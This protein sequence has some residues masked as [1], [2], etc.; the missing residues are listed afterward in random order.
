MNGEGGSVDLLRNPFLSGCISQIRIGG[1]S[2]GILVLI[3]WYGVAGFSFSLV[4]VF[5]C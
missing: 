2:V 3:A 1:T 4:F 5:Q